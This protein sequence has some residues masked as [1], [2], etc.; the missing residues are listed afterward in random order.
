M[1]VGG[2]RSMVGVMGGYEELEEELVTW[3]KE[4]E[5]IEVDMAALVGRSWYWITTVIIER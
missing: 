5:S 1:E 3:E 4:G 2:R